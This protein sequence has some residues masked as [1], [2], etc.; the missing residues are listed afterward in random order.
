M[1]DKCYS[2][3]VTI[4]VISDIV[5]S[6]QLADRDGAQRILD[7]TIERIEAE[8]PLALRQLRPTVADEEQGTY[9]TLGDALASLL[10]LQLALPDQVE[11]RF[12][13][14]IGE[15]RPVASRTGNIEDGA[16]WWAARAAIDIVHAKQQRA[17]P[18]ARTWVVASPGEDAEVHRNVG[19][20]NAYLLTRDQIVGDM[21]ERERRLT[22]GRCLGRTQKDLARAEG[23]T[24]PGVSQALGSAGAHALVEGFALLRAGV[25]G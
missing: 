2:Y 16:G 5:G 7:S 17:A 12:G 20:A 1:Q 23:I 3:F 6:R 9:A 14:G 22:Y 11:C 4:A 21:T 10:L 15:I 19:L 8:L 18:S 24:Q 25:H 13:I